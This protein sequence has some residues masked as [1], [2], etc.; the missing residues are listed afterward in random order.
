M[1]VIW[2]ICSQS[3]SCRNIVRSYLILFCLIKKESLLSNKDFEKIEFSTSLFKLELL[4]LSQTAFALRP[5]ENIKFD[6]TTH[7]WLNK[8]GKHNRKDDGYYHLG[9]I[10]FIIKVDGDSSWESYSTA[11][12]RKPVR[13]LDSES[14]I[15]LAAA[16]LNSTLPESCPVI[17]NRFWEN[18]QDRLNFHSHLK[19]VLLT[20]SLLEYSFE[21]VFAT[22]QVLKVKR[23]YS[24]RYPYQNQ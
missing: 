4:E 13:S 17:V 24:C 14:E 1:L 8:D 20:Q 5:N 11:N 21:Q 7:E 15:V 19:L 23:R 18:L 3:S 12:K 22:D 16:N 10:N 2:I 9:D 6:F